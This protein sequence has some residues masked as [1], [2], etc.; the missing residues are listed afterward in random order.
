M[1]S[2][3]AVG[4]SENS[5]ATWMEGSGVPWDV[6]YAYF[7]YG[8]ADNWGYGS[9]N[10]SWGLGYMQ[11]SASEGFIPAVEYYCMNG[12]PGG[13]EDQFLAKT[14]D[15]TT[16]AEYFGDFKIL[17]QNVKSFGKPVVVLLEADGF[18]FL[19]EQSN[20]DPTTYAAVAASGVPELAS[21]P[22]TV[23]GWGLAFLQLRQ[24][25]GASNAILGIHV[26]AWASTP[27]PRAAA[28]G[29]VANPS[30]P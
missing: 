19:E 7:T 28:H 2:H 8:W 27:P 15:A 4:L 13:G 24:A 11:E 10:G 30:P 29:Y 23:A 16:M 22:N 12:E 1:P 6:R 25:V 3:L 21:L 20:G 5:G 17:M 26:S 9:D 14:Q 18:G